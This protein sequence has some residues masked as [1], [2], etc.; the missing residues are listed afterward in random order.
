MRRHAVL[1]QIKEEKQ[2]ENSQKLFKFFPNSRHKV[3][4]IAEFKVLWNIIPEI[5]KKV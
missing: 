2:S 1:L 3:L 5:E 4:Y